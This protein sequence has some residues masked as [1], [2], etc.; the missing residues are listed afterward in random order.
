M[1]SASQR[2]ARSYSTS[3][4]AADP[5]IRYPRAASASRWAAQARATASSTS[6]QPSSSRP[7]K[8]STEPSVTA[9]S[10][11]VSSSPVSS[12]SAPLPLGDGLL[13]AAVQNVGGGHRRPQLA[14]FAL[15]AGHPVQAVQRRLQPS[16]P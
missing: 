9:V 6:C 10:S 13:E 16:H 8:T 5:I 14:A 3:T 11:S 1:P 4:D 7:A 2:P 15:G 12:L